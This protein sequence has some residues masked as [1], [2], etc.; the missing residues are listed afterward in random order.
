MTTIHLVYHG[1]ITCDPLEMTKTIIQ[2]LVDIPA[3]SIAE[4]VDNRDH[5]AA[6]SDLT[7]SFS[8]ST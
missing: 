1:L 2:D 8:S 6:C 7:F 3:K 5:E 4:K